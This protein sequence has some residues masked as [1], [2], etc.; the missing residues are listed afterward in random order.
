[1]RIVVAGGAGF[2][3]SHLCDQ[4]IGRGDRVVCVDNFVTGSSQ[5]V[6]HLVGHKAFELV[7]QD[8]TQPLA[9]GGGVEAV[10]NFA[11]PASPKDYYALPIETLDVGSLGT[12]NLLELARLKS[13]R[14][15]MASTSEVYGDPA[16][17]PQ[18]ED[19]WGNVNPIG[20]RS[21]YDEAKRFSEALTFAYHRTH[22]VDIRVV[23]IFNTYG[24]RMQP[25]DGRVISNFITQALRGEPLTVYGDGLQT[26]SFCF[27]DD[28]VNGFLALLDGDEIGPVN[29]G[30]PGE[31]TML[32]LA[33][34]VN[35]LTGNEA[36]VTFEPL[37]SD[38][39]KQ[40]KPDIRLAV[41]ALGWSPKIDLRAGLG[42]TIPH[43]AAV[44][45]LAR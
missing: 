4:L 17:H 3:G 8:I 25:D 45:D 30:N 39:P 37:P 32:G 29:I 35:E 40:R 27:V 6:E 10:M 28:E 26:R 20:E 34:L 13:A 44:L 24:P 11:S 36:G 33:N 38:D 12:R 41:E 23:R 19:Y 2:L 31:F 22:E 21:M 15:F 43:F 42:R 1:M 7:E 18:T 9:V 5:N 14:F 16:V